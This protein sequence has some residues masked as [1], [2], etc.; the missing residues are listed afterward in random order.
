V[1]RVKRSHRRFFT[2]L[3][4]QTRRQS[5][6]RSLKRI[7]GITLSNAPV[8]YKN[9]TVKSLLERDSARAEENR[10]IA[11]ARYNRMYKEI[12]VERSVSRYFMRENLEKIK[13]KG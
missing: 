6:R 10:K 9:A 8:I 2:N 5:S 3:Q 11:E 1:N 12:L 4:I 13:G 7:L